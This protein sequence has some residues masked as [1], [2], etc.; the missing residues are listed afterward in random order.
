MIFEENDFF[1]ALLYAGELNGYDYR[2]EEKL[3]PSETAARIAF[4]DKNL[5]WNVVEVASI[6]RKYQINKTNH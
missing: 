1:Y 6:E 3:S 5:C 4:G 2:T